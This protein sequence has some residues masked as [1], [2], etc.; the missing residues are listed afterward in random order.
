MT[1]NEEKPEECTALEECPGG[2]DSDETPNE[3]WRRGDSH[4]LL[5]PGCFALLL[6]GPYNHWRRQKQL[7]WFH[8]LN[9]LYSFPRAAVKKSPTLGSFK[10]QQFIVPWV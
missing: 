10:Q 4:G 6:T 8:S 1:R 7:F 3:L 9:T 5:Q 2:L